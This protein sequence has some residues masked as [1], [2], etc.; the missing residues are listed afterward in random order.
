MTGLKQNLDL[1]FLQNVD[2][3]TYSDLK[4]AAATVTTAQKRNVDW[5]C[6]HFITAMYGE[7]TISFKNSL[8]NMKQ[9]TGETISSYCNRLQE[10]SSMAYSEHEQ[11]EE[12]CLLALLRGISDSTMRQKLNESTVTTYRE[13]VRLAKRLESVSNMFEKEPISILK[14]STDSNN[15]SYS[16]HSRDSSEDRNNSYRGRSPTPY[17]NRQR[18]DSRDRYHSSRNRHRDRSS[19][20]RRNNSRDRRDSRSKRKDWKRE[21][22][23]WKCDKKGHYR[24]ECRSNLN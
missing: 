2:S 11:A 18:S 15:K 1:L 6:K 7:E 5:L 17:R 4:S 22:V 8:L 12:A 13:A 16:N 9:K 10:T 24:S 20:R 14:N 3:S 19:S 21:V 23:C